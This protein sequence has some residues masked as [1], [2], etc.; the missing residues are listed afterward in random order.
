M[1]TIYERAKQLLRRARIPAGYYG[2]DLNGNHYKLVRD[3]VPGGAHLPKVHH[4]MPVC[5]RNAVQ[6]E[7]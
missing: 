5:R 7:T 2:Y 4:H 1:S 3:V 6:Q